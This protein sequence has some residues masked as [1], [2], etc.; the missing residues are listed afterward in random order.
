MKLQ[1]PS[2]SETT[3]ELLPGPIRRQGL[4]RSFSLYLVDLLCSLLSPSPWLW[5]TRASRLWH[6]SVRRGTGDTRWASKDKYWSWII[7]INP[8]C[9]HQPPVPDIYREI[10]VTPPS[11][12]CVSWSWLYIN[13]ISPVLSPACA[14]SPLL[15]TAHPGHCP[16]HSPLT[17]ASDLLLTPWIIV[18]KCDGTLCGRI[19]TPHLLR[20]RAD[21]H[22]KVFH[23]TFNTPRGLNI[24][25]HLKI[26]AI[27]RRSIVKFPAQ[28]WPDF[29]HSLWLNAEILKLFSL[30]WILTNERFFGWVIDATIND[31]ELFQVNSP[32]VFSPFSKQFYIVPLYLVTTIL[33][34]AARPN[35]AAY[36]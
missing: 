25:Q 11:V 3:D 20:S 35:S 17:Q 10:K 2:S 32:V 30:D 5:Q 36:R 19:C 16:V 21:L 26:L 1:L 4:F 22:W 12:F 31:F 7:K 15:L 24:G 34:L 27:T 28:I 8:D 29:D 23:I 13:I 14:G 6:W 18:Q 33:Y 9:V